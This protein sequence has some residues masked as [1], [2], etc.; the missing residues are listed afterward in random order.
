VERPVA[1]GTLV[2]T[3]AEAVLFFVPYAIRTIGVRFVQMLKEVYLPV[4]VPA[5]ALICLLGAIREV[6]S[7]SSISSLVP[8]VALGAV[9]YTATYIAVGASRME[10]A[11]YKSL[12]MTASR[13]VWDPF[14]R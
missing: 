3:I 11:F 9:V 14:R 6:V 12:A 13:I 1:V 5:L 8:A 4:A 2:P 7:P 10:R